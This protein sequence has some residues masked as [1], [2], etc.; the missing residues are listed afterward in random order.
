MR[1]SSLNGLRDYIRLS[2][3]F[4]ESEEIEEGIARLKKTLE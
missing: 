3:V 1:F 4:Y 2:F